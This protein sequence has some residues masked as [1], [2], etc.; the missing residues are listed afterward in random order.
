MAI[1]NARLH[2]ELIVRLAEPTRVSELKAD[3]Q[4][5]SRAVTFLVGAEEDFAQLGQILFVLLNDDELIRVCAT[6]GPHGHC[7]AAVN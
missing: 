2:A 3:H 4:V 6:I 7:F 5:I 1:S